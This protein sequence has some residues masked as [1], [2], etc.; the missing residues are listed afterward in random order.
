MG[1]KW[2]EKRHERGAL[3]FWSGGAD[4]TVLLCELSRRIKPQSLRIVMMKAPRFSSNQTDLAAANK[5]KRKV[6][7]ELD[8]HGTELVHLETVS[9]YLD[10]GPYTGHG[11][12]ITILTQAAIMIRPEDDLYLGWYGTPSSEDHLD[13]M[14]DL[15]QALCRLQGKPSKLVLP[16]RGWTK[17][18]ILEYLADPNWPFLEKVA[19]CESPVKRKGSLKPCGDCTKCREFLTALHDSESLR[20]KARDIATR[21]GFPCVYERVPLGPHK[22]IK[23]QRIR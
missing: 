15:F 6:L 19:T 2:F 16:L 21:M 22:I 12:Q 17:S 4:S 5:M 11:Q 23:V 1:S 14:A 3:A 10:T 13:E 8:P 9:A 18:A 20:P 7:H